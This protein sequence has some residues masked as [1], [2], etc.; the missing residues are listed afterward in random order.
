MKL[1]KNRETK[2][3]YSK[4]QGIPEHILE[5]RVSFGVDGTIVAL[6]SSRQNGSK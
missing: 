4:C 2:S 5:D 6:K 1:V 3:P